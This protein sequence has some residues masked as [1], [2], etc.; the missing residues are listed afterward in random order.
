MS[1][2]WEIVC[3]DVRKVLKTFP[4]N[5]FDA[6]LSDPP[7]GL[8]FM[9]KR[10][11]YFLPSVN[12]WTELLRV[13][14]P[15]AHVMLFGGTRTFHRLCVSVE[16]AGFEVRDLLFFLH[17]KGFPKS[18]AIDKAIDKKK[19]SRDDVLIITRWLK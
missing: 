8:S 4:D 17:G 9:G 5:H 1:K 15:G 14:K 3:G 7:Y 18:L 6:V 2:P 10:W 19:D 11:D 16:D 13:V 12:V